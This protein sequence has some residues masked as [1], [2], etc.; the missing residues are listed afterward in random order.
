MVKS[1]GT[2]VAANP[3]CVLIILV[4]IYFMFSK[5]Y[6]ASSPMPARP[7]TNIEIICAAAAVVVYV[8]C[9]KTGVAVCLPA[10]APAPRQQDIILKLAAN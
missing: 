6:L 4:Y 3:V 9:P 1:G 2:F 7:Q 8:E 5:P 10:G